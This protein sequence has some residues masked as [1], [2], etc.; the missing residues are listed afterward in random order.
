MFLNRLYCLD[1]LISYD[2][3]I[4][5]K[6]RLGNIIAS[7]DCGHRYRTK[8]GGIKEATILHNRGQNEKISNKTCS[9][10]FKIRANANENIDEDIIEYVCKHEGTETPTIEFLKN[11]NLFYQWL[12][13]HLFL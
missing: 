13:K 1:E 3:Q 2:K 10:C 12:Y 9:V 8:Q 4:H 6:Y 7:H 11:K 5:E